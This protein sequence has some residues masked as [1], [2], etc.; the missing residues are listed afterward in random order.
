M[1]FSFFGRNRNKSSELSKESMLTADFSHFENFFPVKTLDLSKHGVRD[2][3]HVMYVSFDPD[4]DHEKAFP[5][6]E[7]HC[8]SGEYP[9]ND[10]LFMKIT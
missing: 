8:G 1:S 6:G 2:K 3:I 4:V 9:P 7:S 5:G 10:P